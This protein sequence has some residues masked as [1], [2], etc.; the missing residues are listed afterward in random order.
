MNHSNIS[1]NSHEI[2]QE[3]MFLDKIAQIAK[4]PA[5]EAIL[6]TTYTYEILKDEN[7]V[8]R[9]SSDGHI[10]AYN[11]IFQALSGKNFASAQEN[12]DEIL[13]ISEQKIGEYL[14]KIAQFSCQIEKADLDAKIK[15]LLRGVLES[16]KNIFTIA[17]KGL[18]FEL[19]KAGYQPRISDDE[20]KTRIDEMNALQT[21]EFG[22]AVSDQ[23]KLVEQVFYSIRKRF[24]YG[25]K[26]LSDEEK[27]ELQEHYDEMREKILQKFPDLRIKDLSDFKADSTRNDLQNLSEIKISQENYVKIFEL[28]LEILDLPQ[29]IEVSEKY[30]SIFDGADLLGIPKNQDYENLSLSRILELIRHEFGHY[31]NQKNSEIF[32]HGVRGAKNVEKEEGLAMLTEGLLAGK[33]LDEIE[34]HGRGISETRMLSEELLPVEKWK[35]NLYLMQRLAG[36]KDSLE[37]LF[38]RASRN[39]PFGKG[40]QRKDLQYGNGL[41]RVIDFLKNGGDIKSLYSGKISIDHIRSGEFNF[42]E[43]PKMQLPYFLEDIVI[44]IAKNTQNETLNHENFLKFLNEKYSHILKQGDFEDIERLTQSHKRKIIEI[45]ALTEIRPK[46]PKNPEKSKKI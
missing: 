31:I 17:L 36:K 5:A 21:Q 22:E 39:F 10:L 32:L 13:Q 4:W 26:N 6:E 37:G 42:S 18:P 46:D 44:F 28:V 34:K 20:Q 41:S 38:R 40:V 30:S 11:Q 45:L 27:R 1:H 19:E 25:K 29:R 15:E 23:P 14:E 12:F 3:Q 35:R 7:S 2:S 9:R 33:K 43:N 16:H 8:P 24:A